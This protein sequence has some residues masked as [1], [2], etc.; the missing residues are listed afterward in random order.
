MTPREFLYWEQTSRDTIDFKKVY[1]DI[2]GDIVSGLLLSQIIF[3]NLPNNEGKS[4]LRIK[5]DDELYL[6]KGREDW[7]EECRITPKQFD[8]A[9][10]VLEDKGL[11]TKV[12]KR[13]NS[14]PT[15][16]IKL[17]IEKLC[18]EI[19]KCNNMFENSKEGEKM[20]LPFGEVRNSPLGNYDIT[21]R[22]KTLTEI[23]T[24][25]TTEKK[26]KYKKEKEDIYSGISEEVKATLEDFIKFRKAIKKP[27]TN[28][29]IKLLINRLNSFGYSDELKIKCLEKSLLQ[30]WSNIY[31]LH[32]DDMKINPAPISNLSVPKN[33]ISNNV[34]VV[35]D[36]EF[37]KKFIELEERKLMEGSYG[38]KS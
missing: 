36:D 17:N 33:P 28:R 32:P 26:E 20:L 35:V 37:I 9:A 15:T 5:I 23:T 34:K 10:K 19:E 30:G 7:W 16:H 29:A 4:K 31:K 24:E 18:Q 1:I 38:N 3:W 21:E 22:V 14:F 6:A 13:F 27:M 25:I 11:I 8:R 12:I 2:A